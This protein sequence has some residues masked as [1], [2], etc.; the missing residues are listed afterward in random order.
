MRLFINKNHEASLI[1]TVG[2]VGEGEGREVCQYEDLRDVISCSE[3][4]MSYLSSSRVLTK[5]T[6]AQ[7]VTPLLG[8][9]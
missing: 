9:T 3:C 7:A 6:L 1:N 4:F 8:S 5:K 2:E